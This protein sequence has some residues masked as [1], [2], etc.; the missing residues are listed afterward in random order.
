MFMTIT[1]GRALQQ[2]HNKG[3]LSCRFDFDVGT[4]HNGDFII[5]VTEG[6]KYAK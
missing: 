6:D 5:A 3:S 2:T 1:A 4:I